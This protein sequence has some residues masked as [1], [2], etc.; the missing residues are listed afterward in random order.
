MCIYLNEGIEQNIT[1][2][3]VFRI[4]PYMLSKMVGSNYP[5]VY[6]NY[7]WSYGLSA[8]LRCP[9]VG[10]EPKSSFLYN[11]IYS[12]IYL[13]GLLDGRTHGDVVKSMAPYDFKGEIV[14]PR[15]NRTDSRL[16]FFS[17]TTNEVTKSADSGIPLVTG[18][19]NGFQ[20]LK[21]E[22]IYYAYVF[23]KDEELNPSNITLKGK[24]ITINTDGT[25]S[26]ECNQAGIG[27]HQVVIGFTYA[28]KYYYG[29]IKSFEIEGVNLCPD[30]NHPHAINLGLPSGTK[31]C[32][33]NVGATAPEGY[34]SYYAWGETSEKSI[35]HWDT[36]AYYNDDTG[37]VNIGFDIAG[38]DYDAATVNM[39]APWRMPS[40]EQQAELRN[41]CSRQWTKQ[42]GVN[43]ILVTGP[44]GGQIFLPAA[45]H[46][47]NGSRLNAFIGGWYW[48]SSLNPSGDGYAYGLYFNSSD[49][50]TNDSGRHYG[51]S[52]R[53]VV[54]P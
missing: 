12:S 53:P 17:I 45:G 46:R 34:G 28:D 2:S 19:I 41:Y 37:Y 52:V 39:G 25:F 4:S 1:N 26:Y 35:Y 6:G 23:G 18:K 50:N 11:C 48:S 49:I 24:P 9:V 27:K 54:K 29:A 3:S 47:Y 14:V 21:E 44:S 33:C 15:T 20:N 10:Y 22:I 16:R 30:N 32:C 51:F 8:K 40:N 13:E 42:N 5:I 36:Y 38:T 43:G 7:C 31:W